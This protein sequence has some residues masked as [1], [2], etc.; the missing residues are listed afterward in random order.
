MLIDANLL[1]YAVHR[2][3]P[4]HAKARDWLTEQLNGARRSDPGRADR[5]S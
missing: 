3:S 5:T 4:F 1:L 2:Q